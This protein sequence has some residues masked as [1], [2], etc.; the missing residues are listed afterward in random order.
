MEKR[1]YVLPE[2]IDADIARLKLK[3]LGISF[4]KLTA[5]QKKYLTSWEM[6]T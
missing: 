5:E 4:D 3:T 2:K 6:G 1:V